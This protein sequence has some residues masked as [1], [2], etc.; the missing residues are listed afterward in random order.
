MDKVPMADEEVGSD[1]DIEGQKEDGD[2]E[3]EEI[4]V[5]GQ[6]PASKRSKTSRGSSAKGKAKAGTGNGSANGTGASGKRKTKSEEA[7]DGEQ[8][9]VNGRVNG[10]D[11]QDVKAKGQPGTNRKD[12]PEGGGVAGKDAEK[13][14]NAYEVKGKVAS[15]EVAAKVDENPPLDILMDLQT[16]KDVKEAEKGESVVYWMRMED[17]RCKSP[18]A[19]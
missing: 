16:A 1:V 14:K 18:L 6:E 3:E 2:G 5:E 10:S 15:A 19:F 13:H 17:L 9:H 7:N 11:G 4:E 8:D 12:S